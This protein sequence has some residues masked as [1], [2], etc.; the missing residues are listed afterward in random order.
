MSNLIFILGDQLSTAL[1]SL[2]DADRVSDIILMAEVHSEAA[3]ANHH[4]QKITLVLSAMRHFALELQASGWKVDY[5]YLDD[6]LNSGTLTDELRR[7]IARNKPDKIVITHPGEWRVM[8]LIRNWQ[9]TLGVQVEI[10]EDDRFFTTLDSFNSWAEGRHILRMDNFYRLMRQQTG[11]LMENGEPAGGRYSYDRENRKSL[12]NTR[13]IP[14]RLVFPADAISREVLR[15]VSKRFPNN[16]GQ[17][18][19]FNWAVTR[20]DAQRA[21]CDFIEK[22]LS[23][24]GDFQDAM[25]SG[26]DTLFHSLI[27]PYLNIGLLSPAEVCEEAERAWRE[28][29]APLNAVEGF[30]RQII[31]WR[32]YVRG[33]YW[34]CMPD[35][36]NSNFLEADLPLPSFYW[37]TETKLNCLNMCLQTTQKNAYAH[38][39]QRLMVIGNFA[40]L[41][42]LAPRAVEEWYLSVYADAFEWVELPNTHGMALF[43][44]GG[45]MAS[46]PYAAS[47][48]YIHRMSDYCRTCRY[49]PKI[50]TGENACPFN[51]L[52]WY[53]LI[54]N[55]SRLKANPRMAIPYSI[56]ARTADED[57]ETLK[58]QAE[59][60]LQKIR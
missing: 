49:S 47:G 11:F 21:L 48:A 2:R 14:G 15:L 42:G 58:Q 7:A 3:Y 29:R 41:A 36:A 38:H 53:F 4:K 57:K 19:P 59:I 13:Q 12:S 56:L 35:Y 10:K 20:K 25:R 44:D 43:A 60:F 33:I 26:H 24:F 40:L 46:K 23:G 54:R 9:S 34:R 37:N 22:R 30:I 28:G 50:R 18:E 55:S 31:G 8:Q 45:R 51:Y 1:S 6:P 17:L 16:F 32:E 39:I 27:S 52:Y 5:I